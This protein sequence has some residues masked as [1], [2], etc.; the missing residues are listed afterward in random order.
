MK[1]CRVF[2]TYMYITVDF[3]QKCNTEQFFFQLELQQT[4]TTDN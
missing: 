2:I 3:T 1:N 4:G